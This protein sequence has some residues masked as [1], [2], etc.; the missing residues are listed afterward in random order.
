MAKKVYDDDDGRTIVDMNVDGMPGFGPRL[1]PRRRKDKPKIDENG[2]EIVSDP[3]ALPDDSDQNGLTKKEMRGAVFSAMLAG[4]VVALVFSAGLILF[5]L[6]CTD[7]WF[8]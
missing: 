5:T 3:K 4:L 1:F 7:I 8:R 6:F 2:M